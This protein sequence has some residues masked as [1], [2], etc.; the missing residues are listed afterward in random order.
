[1]LKNQAKMMST[2]YNFVCKSIRGKEVELS[3]YR[4]NVCLIVNLASE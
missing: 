4:G 3:Q 2:I 1:M